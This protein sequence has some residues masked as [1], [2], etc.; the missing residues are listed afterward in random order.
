MR[1]SILFPAI[2][3]AIAGM[4]ISVHAQDASPTA[5]PQPTDGVVDRAQDKVSNMTDDARPV[6]TLL[7]NAT[8]AAVSKD[9]FDNLVRRFVDADRDRISKNDLNDAD[10]AKLNGRIDQFR[11]DWKAKYNQDFDIEKEELV[12]NDQF[13]IVRG[14]IGN[15][16]QPAAGKMDPGKPDTSPG[17]ESDK[18]GGGDVNR[19]PGR[20]VAKVTFPASHGMPVLYIPLINE[21]PSMWKIDVPDQVD[22]RKLYNNLL[23]QLTFADEHKAMWPADVNDAYRAISHHVFC[24]ILDQPLNAD[25]MNPGDMKPGDMKPGD[26]KPGEMKP[27]DMKP[28]DMDR[29]R[30]A[31]PR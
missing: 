18:L 26:M 29:D 21:F 28:G 2:A 22:G 23:E 11:K 1:K 25:N 10:W 12:Y 9:G 15:E 7:A 17:P 6:R 16:A 31:R 14:E 20:N 3:V 4:S 19:D 8:E 13:R 24:A 5:Q 30:P 27:G